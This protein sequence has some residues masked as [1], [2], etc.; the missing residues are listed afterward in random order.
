ML[1]CHVNFV[2]VINYWS[3]RNVSEYFT[4]A[5]NRSEMSL[6]L[7]IYLFI[8]T[9]FVRNLDASFLTSNIVNQGNRGEETGTLAISQSTMPC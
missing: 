6:F 1:F 5:L 2:T 4:N 8:S 9:Y 7:R 3:K